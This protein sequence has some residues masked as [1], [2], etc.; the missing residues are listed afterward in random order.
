MTNKTCIVI[1]WD[2]E[3]VSVM[4]DEAAHRAHEENWRL[5]IYANKAEAIADVKETRR[6]W[7][8]DEEVVAEHDRMLELLKAL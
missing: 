1:D 4:F 7:S 2:A 5:A 6:N 8:C 3:T